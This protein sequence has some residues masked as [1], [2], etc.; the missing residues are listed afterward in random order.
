MQ[1]RRFTRLAFGI[2]ML[3]TFL[4]ADTIKY[5]YDAAGRLTSASY[6]ATTIAYSYDKAGNLLSRTTSGSATL[7]TTVSAADFKA[8]VAPD[9]LV[10]GFGQALISGPPVQA[11]TIPLPT[12][13]GQTQ[14]Q[15]KDAS[16]TMSFCRL[17]LISATQFNFITPPDAAPGTATITVLNSGSTV[18]SGTVQVAKVAPGIFASSGIAAAEI[19]RVQADG[20]QNIEFV[21]QADASG[22]IIPLPIDFGAATDHLYLLLFG[23]GIRGNSGLAGVTLSIGNT[24][25]PVAYAGDQRGFAGLDQINTAELPR[26]LAGSGQVNVALTI[27]GKAATPVTLVFK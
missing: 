7:F 15:F 23:T 21:V 20:S 4:P 14:V 27:D 25:V 5:T 8:P 3:G 10:S 22:N 19:L 16:G 26:S 17:V 9:S 11:S 13:L 6:G 18:A 1:V 2:A 12:M 24:N